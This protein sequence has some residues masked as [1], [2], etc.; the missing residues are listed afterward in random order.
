MKSTTMWAAAALAAL[1]TP[2]VSQQPALREAVAQDY[3]ANLAALFDHFHRNPE[4][5]G[6]EVQTAARMARELRALG[7]EVEVKEASR[8]AAPLPE[9]E[10]LR[11]LA[12]RVFG[13]GAPA[14]AEEVVSLAS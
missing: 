11:A 8:P 1:A 12:R 4:L 9:A 2:A 3:R 6:R 10:D 13:A 14:K 7:Y 5:S